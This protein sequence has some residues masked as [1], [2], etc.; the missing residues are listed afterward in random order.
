M[1]ELK[2]EVFY[3]V[4]YSGAM[5]GWYSESHDISTWQAMTLLVCTYIRS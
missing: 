3:G 5:G 4:V 1:N 2:A